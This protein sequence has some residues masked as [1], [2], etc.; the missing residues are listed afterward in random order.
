MNNDRTVW[1][2]WPEEKPVHVGW[3][4]MQTLGDRL[5]VLWAGTRWWD[6]VRW[7]MF[8]TGPVSSLSKPDQPYLVEW[9]GL[10][11]EGYGKARFNVDEDARVERL[12]AERARKHETLYG[13]GTYTW[14]DGSNED[15]VKWAQRRTT[16][17]TMF[18]ELGKFVGNSDDAKPAPSPYEAL[19]DMMRKMG[20][21][22]PKVNTRIEAEV[23]LE[24]FLSMNPERLAQINFAN[25]KAHSTDEVTKFASLPKFHNM[26]KDNA[27]VF[28]ALANH[29]PR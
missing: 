28:T 8:D 18:A 29:G 2:A 14:P 22:W 4:E 13:P 19:R 17:I 7:R 11:F 27:H 5:A 24:N 1:F 21:G 16:P 25:E 6:G 26:L 10:T 23:Q 3:Y 15:W 12:L 9:R 20:L